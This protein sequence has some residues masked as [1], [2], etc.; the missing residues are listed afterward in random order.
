[1]LLL[2]QWAKLVQKFV[3]R[4]PIE[5]HS[6]PSMHDEWICNISVFRNVKTW[7]CQWKWSVC[8]HSLI[9]GT[10]KSCFCVCVCDKPIRTFDGRMWNGCNAGRVYITPASLAIN[11]EQLNEFCRVS[12]DILHLHRWC[13]SGGNKI[14]YKYKWPLYAIDFVICILT[15]RFPEAKFNKQTVRVVSVCTLGSSP[16]ATK[17]HTDAWSTEHTRW[18]FAVAAVCACECDVHSGAATSFCVSIKLH[19]FAWWI[20]A[21]RC[22]KNDR[23]FADIPRFPLNLAGGRCN[24]HHH[25]LTFIFMSFSIHIIFRP[26]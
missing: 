16:V 5:S 6:E 21:I 19:A 15:L 13:C 26:N 23:I 24:H 3:G 4:L 22:S 11:F 8:S 14:I 2:H 20:P 12:N 1:M 10:I 17:P 18:M 7:K 9:V 25:I